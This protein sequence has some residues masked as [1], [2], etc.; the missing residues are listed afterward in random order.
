MQGKNFIKFLAI[1]LG[2]VCVYT[3]S[4]NLVTS[5]V[6]ADADL[7]AN[8][9]PL[10]RKNYLDS[11]ATQPVYPLFDF[12]YQ[13]CKEKE[14]N[15]GLDLKGG[16]NVTMEI[17]L[18]E[19]IKSLA[20]NTNDV[21]FNQAIANAQTQMNLG[22]RDFVTAF[23]SEYEKLN[24]KG[25]L[26]DLFANQD[27]IADLKANA[28]NTDVKK[29]L[30]KQAESAIDRSFIILRSRI[31]GFGVV[32][33][34]MQKQQ[35]TNRILIELPGVEDKDRVRKLLSGT[36]EL[37]FWQVYSNQEVVSVMENINKTLAVILKDTTKNSIDTTKKAAG[38]LASLSNDT[39][40]TKTLEERKKNPLYTVLSIPTFQQQNGQSSLRPGPVVGYVAQKDTAKVFSYFAKKEIASIIPQNM[41]FMWS[42][43]PFEGT[44]VY[45]LYA[46]KVT[47][48]DGKPALGGDAVREA[49]DD[50]DQ[51]GRPEV[52]MYMT[53]DGRTQWKKITAEAASNP[54]DKKAIAI[55]LD[56]TVY[57]APTV[58]NEIPD[59]VS[60]ISGSFT[61]ND[62]KDLAN[63]LKAGQLPAPAKIIGE[64]VVG[65]SLGQ[66]AIDN[67]LSS[68]L[69]GLIVVLAF[70]VLYYN[71]AG[72]IANIAVLVNIFF[73]MGVLASLHAV[74]T[75]PG[76]AGIV[77][78]LGMAVDANVLIYERV[79]EELR[80]GKTKKQAIADGFHNAL[81]SI[82]D[83]N[84]TTFLTGVVLAYF[85]TGPI[86]G[87]ATTM[88]VGIATSLFT[89]IFITRIIF[90]WMLEKDIDIK[91]SN[92]FSANTFLKANFSFVKNRF[93]FYAFSGLFITA[94][95]VSMFTK[96]FTYGVDISGGRSYVISFNKAVPTDQVRSILLEELKGGS[97]EVKKYGEGGSVLATT[98]YLISD[99]SAEAD[100]TVESKV[101][102]AL[103]KL[104][105][106]SKIESSQKVSSTIAS[107]VKT[108]AFYAVIASIIIIALYIFF[109][110]R[111][112]QFGLG[113]LV[114]LF[115]DVML[116]L[117]FFTLFNGILP[118][119]LDIDQ[120]FI[121][122]ILTVVGYSIND[123]VVVFD[124]IREQ[125]GLH[126]TDNLDT[127][128][129][130][131]NAINSTL[132]RT[133]ITALT[134]LFVLVV[135]FIFG[136]DVLKG[137]SFAL[138]I[139]VIFGTYS[140]I[141]I[142][143]PVVIDFD[144]KG[145]K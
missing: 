104:N 82:L 79:R 50:F 63:I 7:Y 9:D 144:K 80:N 123:T 118:F 70:M 37:Q 84:I 23:I 12:N 5:S 125:L 73:L 90:E 113:A 140:S 92:P 136:G 83:G 43:K 105:A 85:G 72:L 42:A 103:S 139:G 78:T 114:A 36:A 14:I 101:L 65:P 120:A 96:G 93:K 89:A 58:Q 138:L 107:D 18:A 34:N 100:K 2:I 109:R 25:N 45:E 129:V 53:A 71:N 119:P 61:A 66:E 76:I 26:A 41:K 51:K 28:S 32:S 98:S 131:N 19:L 24:P 87:F 59:G 47:S 95:I 69:I 21:V 74:L 121:A 64:Q 142:A 137:F 16:M 124:R 52:T 20:N 31:D 22:A 122:A 130:I 106:S 88:M 62:T 40:S 117:S 77:L 1:L 35:G 99:N 13:F 29:Y 11:M 3:L 94:G 132:S 143:T 44:K 57:S 145:L 15:L 10:K 81:P 67:G 127:K 46:I 6:E 17:S 112:W 128:E 49:R 110:F 48:I 86:R 4:F 97:T 75:L 54:N 102:G 68:T 8:G 91:F 27:N 30:N 33:P 60:S 134:V 39:T 115:H 38:K 133:I 141:C 135:L 56:N 126:K 116:V 108:G 111:K 55:V